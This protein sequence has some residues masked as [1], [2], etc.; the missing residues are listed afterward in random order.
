MTQIA[1][2][3]LM[4]TFVAVALIFAIVGFFFADHHSLAWF[5]ENDEATATGLSVNAKISPNLVIGK[6]AEQIKQDSLLFSVDFSGT[7]RKNMIAV[8]RDEKVEGT[9]LK[10]VKD[11]YAVDHK[12]GN[13]KPGMTLAFEGVPVENN[14]PYFIDYTV[15]IASAFDPLAV[16][17]LS[18]TIVIPDTVDDL[19]PYPYAVSIDFYVGEVSES[20]Y[21]GTTSVADCIH[22]TERANVELFPNNGTTVP[23]NTEGYIK[24]IMRCYFDGALQDPQTGVAY[25]NSNTVRTDG[26]VIGVDF[27][28]VDAET[29]E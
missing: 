26:V 23:L 20:A 2:Q 4:I 1:K 10:Y 12:T 5:S 24:V 27:T 18:A 22:Q 29:A 15:Y 14:E 28:A 8:T 25:V 19:H 11:H 16:S 17:S 6:S 9:F 3:S 7:A 21:R 13:A